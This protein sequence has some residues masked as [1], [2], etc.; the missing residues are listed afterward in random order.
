MFTYAY[1][2]CS[3][4]FNKPSLQSVN[5]VYKYILQF[6]FLSY[7]SEQKYE[8]FQTGMSENGTIHI[9]MMKKLG[10]LEKRGLIEYLVA[11]KK[12]AIRAA[13]PYYVIYR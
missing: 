6:W 4:I 8:Y 3:L 5:K 9:T 12:E 2:Y 13:H 7:I 11:R 10:H 1:M